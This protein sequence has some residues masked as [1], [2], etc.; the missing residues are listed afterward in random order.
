MLFARR[1][2]KFRRRVLLPVRARLPGTV[3]FLT[4]LSMYLPRTARPPAVDSL[5]AAAQKSAPDKPP[6]LRQV[7]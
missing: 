4:D 7:G 6:I 3:K 5:M 1:R 2:S